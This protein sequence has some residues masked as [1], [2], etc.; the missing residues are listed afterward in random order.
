[1]QF[2]IFHGSFGNPEE[3]WFPWLKEELEKLGQDVLSPQ[4]PVDT[5]ENITELGE[6][7]LSELQNLTNWTTAFEEEVLPKLKHDLPLC[8]VGHSLAPVFI[9]HMVD[10]HNL[11]L[12]SAMFVAPFLQHLGRAWQIDTVNSSF[13]KTDFDFEKLKKLIPLSY[14]FISDND[15]YVPKDKAYEFVEKIGSQL[16]LIENGGHFNNSAGFTTFPQL[17]DLCKT[18]ISL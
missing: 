8:F 15:P 17:L 13:Y 6:D 11:Q 14:A 5:W 18:R 3:N 9:L 1:M 10:K 4:F 16:V 2:V 7:H 12:D